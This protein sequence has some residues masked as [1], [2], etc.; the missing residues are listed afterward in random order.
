MPANVDGCQKSLTIKYDINV[1]IAIKLINIA[2]FIY[3]MIFAIMC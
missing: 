2:V 1:K 3:Y